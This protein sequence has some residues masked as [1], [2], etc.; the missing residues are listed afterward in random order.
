MVPFD[1]LFLWQTKIKTI[2]YGLKTLNDTIWIKK[3]EF[4]WWFTHWH[5]LISI[6]IRFQCPKGFRPII[7]PKKLVHRNHSY[8]LVCSKRTFFRIFVNLKHLDLVIN[9]Y[10]FPT[11]YI[12]I[13]K[14]AICLWAIFFLLTQSPSLIFTIKRKSIVKYK[15]T[16][17]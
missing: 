9:W 10:F 11:F 1:H 13:L 5:P 15:S 6:F 3:K 4:Y 14:Y 16:F 2:E 12:Q 17:L 7:C 8:F